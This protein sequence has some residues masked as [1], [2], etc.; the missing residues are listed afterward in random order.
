MKQICGVRT[1]DGRLCQNPVNKTTQRCAAGHLR[2]PSFLPS[3]NLPDAGSGLG[4]NE[5]YD[6]AKHPHILSPDT[7]PILDWLIEG[8]ERG[9]ERFRDVPNNL[10]YNPQI[11]THPQL[12]RL[13]AQYTGFSYDITPQQFERLMRIM[14]G[15]EGCEAFER[16][17]VYRALRRDDLTPDGFYLAALR[18]AKWMNLDQRKQLWDVIAKQEDLTKAQ[19]KILE[20]LITDTE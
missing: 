3:L 5:I 14:D 6:L 20:S 18:S 13:V 4:W 9:D 10:A 16:G 12:V 8:V 19:R 11:F 2:L 7:K 17:V 15:R 1:K